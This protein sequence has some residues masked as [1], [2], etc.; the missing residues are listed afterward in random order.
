MPAGLA[1]PPNRDEL[2][3]RLTLATPNDNAKYDESENPR[4]DPDQRC[5]V[6]ISLLLSNSRPP[7]VAAAGKIKSLEESQLMHQRDD[8]RAQDN[9]H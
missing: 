9:H 5:C 6:H 7:L 8:S 4:H 3:D 1:Y 2:V